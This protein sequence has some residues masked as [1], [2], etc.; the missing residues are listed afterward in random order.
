MPSQPPPLPPPLPTESNL[1]YFSPYALWNNH[2]ID[3]TAALIPRRL[4]TT[5]SIDVF[6]DGNC[7]LRSGGKIN[8]T[9]GCT[10]TF[11]DA[12]GTHTVTLT[13]G[14]GLLRSFPYALYIDQALVSESRVPVSNWWLGPLLWLMVPPVLIGV[15]LLLYFLLR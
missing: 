14:L 3:V 13:W 2:R 11:T 7:I 8:L 12:Q 1:P 9:G 6:I 10:N 15:P 5:A 4:W